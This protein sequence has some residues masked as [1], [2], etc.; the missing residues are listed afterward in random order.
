MELF[1]LLIISIVFWIKFYWIG[2]RHFFKH[3]RTMIKTIVLCLMIIE[4]IV[5]LIRQDSHFRVTRSLRPVFLI[6][7]HYFHGVRR[8]I[9][10]TI[11]SLKS[12][13]LMLLL[14]SFLLLLFSISAFYM[15]SPIS[16][17]D[18]CYCQFI[19]FII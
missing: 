14:L 16:N 9:R 7:N 10:Q 8:V 12:F 2:P 11:L 5:V 19:N 18:V 1:G 3:R 17:Y 13:A 15:F 6:D 4:A